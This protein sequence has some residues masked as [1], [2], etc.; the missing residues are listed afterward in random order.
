MTDLPPNGAPFPQSP[1]LPTLLDSG[2]TIQFRCRKGI[3]CWNA[4]CSNID[5]SLTPYDILRLKKRLDLPA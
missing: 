2:T 5:V 4:C 1:V 3:A